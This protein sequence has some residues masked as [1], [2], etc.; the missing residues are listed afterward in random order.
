MEVVVASQDDCFQGQVHQGPFGRPRP[1]FEQALP[2][3]SQHD[4]CHLGG[5]PARPAVK[6]GEVERWERIEEL[7]GRAVNLA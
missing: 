2:G 3:S 1:R 5:A 6:R 4:I 7:S